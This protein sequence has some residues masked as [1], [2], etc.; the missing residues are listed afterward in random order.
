[1][2][3]ATGHFLFS[4]GP[5]THF[6]ADT[7]LGDTLNP[8]GIFFSNL[9]PAVINSGEWEFNFFN[10]LSTLKYRD[11]NDPSGVGRSSRLDQIAQAWHNPFKGNNLNIGLEVRAAHQ[12]SDAD[13]GG[14][15]FRALGG[16]A[17]HALSALGLGVRVK[18]F[19]S[20]PELNIQSSLV[21]PVAGDELVRQQLGV[22][23]TAWS[24]QGVFYQQFRPWLY[25][26]AVAGAVTQFKNDT[27]EQTSLT[28]P[29]GLYFVAALQQQR[30]YLIPS[31]SC[32]AGYNYVKADNGFNLV[33]TSFL[34]GIGVQYRPAPEW[35]IGLQLDRNIHQGPDN[36]PD[37]IIG[38]SLNQISLGLRYLLAR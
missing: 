9:A 17:V 20:L 21:F 2:N 34:Y 8:G 31:L 3:T 16:D 23:R 36:A 37:R 1:M 22:D 6:A 28:I 4:S 32:A 29:A 5:A 18:P 25:V 35:S 26:F 33:N 13:E 14:S 24:V 38:G 27:R 10:A 30:W 7:L 15:P 12:I 11:N 19:R